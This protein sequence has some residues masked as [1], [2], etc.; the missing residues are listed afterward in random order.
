MSDHGDVARKRI[1]H[2][3]QIL[4]W[5]VE[6]ISADGDNGCDGVDRPW[7]KELVRAKGT[8]WVALDDEFGEPDDFQERH[9]N[10]FVSFL[11]PVQR[12]LYGEPFEALRRAEGVVR[13][14]P[15]ATSAE[16]GGALAVLRR[17]DIKAVRVTLDEDRAPLALAVAHVDLHLFG[18]M[19]IAVLAVEVHADDIDFDTGLET[20]PASATSTF[21]CSCSPTC[22]RPASGCSR[23]GSS[24]PPPSS[25][26]ATRRARGASAGRCG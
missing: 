5:P 17:H 9:Y 19:D 26:P 24:P 1:A 23:T 10:E 22:R 12:F 4:L 8:P 25:K 15:A 18:D 11:P 3:R 2:L 16:A 21:C 6:L 7:A 13:G 20:L 14:K